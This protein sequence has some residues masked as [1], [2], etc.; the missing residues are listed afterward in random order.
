MAEGSKDNTSPNLKTIKYRFQHTGK[1]RLRPTIS[2][3][4]RECLVSWITISDLAAWALW[5]SGSTTTG[6]T[7]AFAELTKVKVDTLQDP[8][9]LQ[10]ETVGSRFIIKYGA[11]VM[12]LVAKLKTTTY[13]DIA[14][15]DHYDMIVGT[16]WMRKHKVVLDFDTNRVIINGMPIMAIKVTA[17]ETD[18][19]A[20]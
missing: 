19:Q 17:K 9:V 4:E 11:D 20:R 2:Q 18:P 6:I 14:N 10:L 7:P 15:F 1:T 16:P 3:E 12:I 5:D 8:H 13:V